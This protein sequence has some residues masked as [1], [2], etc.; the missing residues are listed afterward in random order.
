[1]VV[2]VDG[3]GISQQKATDSNGNVDFSGSP[4]KWQI[5]A[6]VP[7]YTYFLIYLDIVKDDTWPISL[8]KVEVAQEPTT[9]VPV[10]Q[11]SNTNPEISQQL[12]PAPQDI[13]DQSS[14][15]SPGDII[16]A[17]PVMDDTTSSSDPANSVDQDN[18]LSENGSEE[19]TDQDFGP[20]PSEDATA[21]V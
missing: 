20:P 7:G 14:P 10:D 18:Y 21:Q 1:V 17:N 19:P 5:T 16:D 3:A 12:S 4:G 13:V 9:S 6:S 15:D 11:G 8:Q 2:T